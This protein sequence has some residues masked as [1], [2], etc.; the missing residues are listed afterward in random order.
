MQV[1]DEIE[2]RS[3]SNLNEKY[4]TTA[5][6]SAL[7]QGIGIILVIVGI[8]MSL[9]GV[10]F[11]VGIPIAISGFFLIAIAQVISAVVS[12]SNSSKETANNTREILEL[13]K[14]KNK[15]F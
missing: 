5:S 3:T 9:N 8:V 15:E 6:L 7:F 4:K 2:E 10:G 1:I 11:L 14:G 13:L 12:T